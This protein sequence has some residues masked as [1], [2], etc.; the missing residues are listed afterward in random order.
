MILKQSLLLNTP[1]IS[2]ASNCYLYESRS[3]RFLRHDQAKEL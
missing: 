3:L 1:L 2:P